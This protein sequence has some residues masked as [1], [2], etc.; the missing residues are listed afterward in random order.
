MLND[1]EIERYARQVV[2]PEIGGRG[3][4]RLL[5]SR[6]VVLG[7]GAASRH[8]A[9]L[10]RRAG[11]PVSEGEAT[12]RA[13]VVIDLRAGPAGPAPVADAPVVMAR[14]C[15]TRATLTVLPAALCRVCGASEAGGTTAPDPLTTCGLHALAALAASEAVLVLLAPAPRARRYTIDL[16]TGTLSA[17]ALATTRCPHGACCA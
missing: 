8:A 11:V 13:D 5:A 9:D 6:A 1:T 7:E 17:T 12:E 14:T 15:G 4:E 10:L 2:L 16:A 3:Q